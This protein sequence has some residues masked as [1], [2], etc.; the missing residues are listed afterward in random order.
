MRYNYALGWGYWGGLLTAF[1]GI[2]FIVL[3]IWAIVRATTPHP[4]HSEQLAFNYTQN[5][6]IQVFE[7]RYLYTI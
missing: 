5:V 3:L 7:L 6:F 1:V 4:T 2:A